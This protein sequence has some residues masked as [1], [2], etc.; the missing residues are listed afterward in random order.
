MSNMHSGARLR[1][2][3]ACLRSHAQQQRQLRH[4][5]ARQQ[6]DVRGRG[7]CVARRVRDRDAHVSRCE[8]WRV[9]D[10][11]ANLPHSLPTLM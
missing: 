10:A 8:R 2:H 11:V 1:E 6:Q 9:V 7:G 3:C 5:G 4:A